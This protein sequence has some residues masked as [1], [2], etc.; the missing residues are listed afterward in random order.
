MYEP[1][2]KIAD[3]LQR[4]ARVFQER[5]YIV[6]ASVFPREIGSTEASFKSAFD[7][8]LDIPQAF[9]VV[10]QTTLED[11]VAQHRLGWPDLPIAV[12]PEFKYF[13]RIETD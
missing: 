10:S 5:G 3:A 4:C 1:E 11:F 12:I 2:D 13:Y 6:L 8:V 7:S 9:R